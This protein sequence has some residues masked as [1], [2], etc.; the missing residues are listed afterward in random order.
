MELIN[1]SIEIQANENWIVSRSRDCQEFEFLFEMQSDQVEIKLTYYFNEK[2]QSRYH[3][4]VLSGLAQR[5]LIFFKKT[6]E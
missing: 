6:I 2:K 5:D 4:V 1:N 3:E